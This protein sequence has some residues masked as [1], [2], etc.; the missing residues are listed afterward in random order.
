MS[1]HHFEYHAFLASTVGEF[2]QNVIDDTII[3]N[4][5]PLARSFMFTFPYR[6]HEPSASL[7][8]LALDRALLSTGTYEIYTM[9]HYRTIVTRQTSVLH[10]YI[11]PRDFT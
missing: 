6:L 10:S 4:Q 11:S 7:R 8:C 1:V 2:I 5:D 3:D 9:K